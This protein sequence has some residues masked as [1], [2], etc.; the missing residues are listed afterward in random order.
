MSKILVT[1]AT[2]TLGRDLTQKLLGRGHQ[3][4]VFTRQAQPPVPDGVEVHQGNIREG[5]GL[6]EATKGADT[7]IHCVSVYEE[8]FP[9]DIQGTR[10]LI[11]VAKT[12][13]SP[14]VIFISIV[15]IDHSPFPYFQAKLQA[16][17]IV[18]QSDLPW[19]IL[20]ATQFHNYILGVITSFEDE[21]AKTITIPAASRF[22]PIDSGEVADALIALVDQ[23]AS[24][25]VPDVGGPQVL[26]L[27]EIAE[28]YTRVFHKQRAIHTHTMQGEYFDAFRNDEKLNPDRAIGHITW[29]QFLQQRKG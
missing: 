8:G 14:H 1:G 3:V 28:T 2:G 16:E 19:S 17:R 27:D 13:G 4:R 6:L 5:S 11:E 25:R 26:T 7:I 29:E 20:R 24:G 18:E 21:Q 22:Q 12:N 10:N 15:G 9:T 23:E